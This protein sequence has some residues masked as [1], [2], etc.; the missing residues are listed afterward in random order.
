L[1]LTQTYPT[2]HIFTLAG[3][4]ATREHIFTLA[5]LGAAREYISYIAG[6]GAAIA[7]AIETLKPVG[8]RDTITHRS[9]RTEV[10][11]FLG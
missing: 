8:K 1:L 11:I 10:L 3:L 9:I 2:K 7:V 5:G 4:G 6:L